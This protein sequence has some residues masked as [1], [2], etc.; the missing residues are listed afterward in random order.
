MRTELTVQNPYDFGVGRKLENLSALRDCGFA[1]TRRVLDV[2]KT[3]QD[4]AMSEELFQEVTGPRCVDGQR[5]SAAVF[6]LARPV[7][8]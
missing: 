6:V 2:Q 5:A 1:T 7:Y 8:L 3:S 4:F